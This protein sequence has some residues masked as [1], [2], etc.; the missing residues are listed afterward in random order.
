MDE[1]QKDLSISDIQSSPAR[2]D[3]VYASCLSTLDLSSLAGELWMSA[4]A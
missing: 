4:M 2:D 3:R 1:I